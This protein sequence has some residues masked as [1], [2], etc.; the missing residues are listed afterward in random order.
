MY[1]EIV[2]RQNVVYP[3][4]R[5]GGELCNWDIFV[6]TFFALLIDSNSLV[7]FFVYMPFN[8][9]CAQPLLTNLRIISGDTTLIPFN[10]MNEALILRFMQKHHLL[11]VLFIYIQEFSVLQ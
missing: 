1:I 10:L 4:K 5:Y 8:Q 9:W 11:Y 3:L 2:S 6:L 7:V